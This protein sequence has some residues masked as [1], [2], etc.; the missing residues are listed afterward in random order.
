MYCRFTFRVVAPVSIG[1]VLVLAI[2]GCSGLGTTVAPLMSTLVAGRQDASSQVAT[3][4]AAD[5]RLAQNWL[6][7]KVCVDGSDMPVAVDP[8]NSS[9]P[10]GAACK[11]G[12]QMRNIKATDP[13]PYYRVTGSG[14]LSTSIFSYSIPIF[15]ATGEQMF[16]MDRQFTPQNSPPQNWYVNQQYYPG[17]THYDLYRLQ[18]GWV[19]NAATRDNS[20]LNQT[21]FGS[22]NGVAT[23]YNGWV[24]FP[25][26]FLGAFGLS[27]HAN[28]PVRDIHWE[29][30]GLRW[31]LPLQTAPTS[32]TTQTTWSLK[33]LYTFDSGKTM[34]TIES[35]HQSKPQPDSPNSDNGHIEI[36]YFTV[37]YGP[38][39]WEVWSAA[40][41]AGSTC[42]STAHQYCHATGA[43]TFPYGSAKVTYYRTDCKDYTT[44]VLATHGSTLP[45]LPVAETNRLTNF[46]FSNDPLWVV[47]SVSGWTVNAMTVQQLV[48]NKSD[49]TDSGKY[50]PGVR[51][52]K[53]SCDS[54]CALYQDVPLSSVPSGLYAFGVTGLNVASTGTLQV[55]LSQVNSNGSVIAGSTTTASKTVNAIGDN[56][57]CPGPSVVNCSTYVG[58]TA[59]ITP[60]PGAV[61]LR[62]SISAGIG[63]GRFDIIEAYLGRR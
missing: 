10:Y 29:Q 34:N 8:F 16:I 18:N 63:A 6:A 57:E 26:T 41:C 39:R 33:P 52:L 21:F 1:A 12:Y 61:S 53:A 48:S 3:S 55:T 32:T 43:K 31:P 35:I 37:P 19:S 60:L 46:H 30:T 49:D 27:A 36:W 47:G 9:D 15:S 17:H 59:N 22:T 4:D 28:L 44:T 11:G 14:N 38:S 25:L 45:Q 23:P 2:G 56:A 13:V 42:K 62:E 54:A 50:S 51:Y 58:G 40:T 5:V 24:D 20:G 7:Q